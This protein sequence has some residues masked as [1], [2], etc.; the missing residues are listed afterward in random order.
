MLAAHRWNRN[1]LVQLL[2]TLYSDIMK[3]PRA[4]P[5]A[6]A[7]C[8][9]ETPA[10]DYSWKNKQSVGIGLDQKIQK[11]NPQY[12]I[13]VLC[14]KCLKLYFQDGTKNVCPLSRFLSTDRGSGICHIQV[15]A[16]RIGTV[17]VFGIRLVGDKNHKCICRQISMIGGVTNQSLCKSNKTVIFET[18]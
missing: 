5:K 7:G 6:P 17:A 10:V 13:H 8:S 3:S 15:T 18:F 11:K 9:L 2:F 16:Q 14:H 1:L 12:A 4:V